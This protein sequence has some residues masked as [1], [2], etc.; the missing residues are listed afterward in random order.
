[1]EVARIKHSP[2]LQEQQLQ[3]SSSTKSLQ[4]SAL[5]QELQNLFLE[6]E[7]ELSLP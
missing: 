6:A 2:D 4:V 1:M 5:C 7:Q 3:A